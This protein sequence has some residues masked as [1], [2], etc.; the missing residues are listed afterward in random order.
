VSLSAIAEL[1]RRF[2]ENA[3]AYF[4]PYEWQAEFF[5]ARDEFGNLAEQ[6][7]VRCANQVGKTYSGAMGVAIHSTGLYPDWWKGRR[8]DHAPIIWVGGNTIP[9]TRDLGQS[10]LIGEAGDNDAFGTGSIPKHL[11]GRQTKYHGI[12]DALQS[13]L[14]KHVTGKWSKIVFKAYEQGKDA[15]MGKGVDYVWGDEEMPYEIYSQCLRATL[16]KRGIIAMTATPENGLTQLMR[17]FSDDRG[18]GQALI[19]ATWDDAPHLDEE[20]K[21]QRLASLLPF[22]R[23]MRSKGI[24]VMGSGLVFPISESEIMCD[25]FVIPSD[26][27]KIA[28]IDFAGSGTDGHPTAMVAIAIDPENNTSY[29]YDTYSESSKSI[30]QHWLSIKRIGNIPIAWPHDGMISDRGSGIS[31]SQQYKNEGANML[32][33]KFSNPPLA[34]KKEGTG[35]NGVKA[36]LSAMYGAMEQ[37]RFKVFS[38]QVKWFEE[39]R[40]YYQKDNDIV[41][42]HD[43]LMSATRYAYMSGRFAQASSNVFKSYT[44]QEQDYADS[45]IGY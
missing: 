29:V 30:P 22:E 13:V 19:T 4:K 8:F 25:P 36:G 44:P 43:D 21:A 10:E 37:G 31:Y 28:G 41:K 16:R 14:V 2:R 1:E 12:P 11:I 33:D 18:K 26:W 45:V 24:P 39:F 6:I 35:G 38:N 7:L 23:E 32:P 3:L 20:T 5:N 40:Q 42:E 9:N 27:K 34:G 17:I 15:W